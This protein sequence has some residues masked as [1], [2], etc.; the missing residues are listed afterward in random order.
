MTAFPNGEVPHSL[1][2]PSR[3]ATARNGSVLHALRIAIYMRDLAGGG[4]ER[5]AMTLAFELQSA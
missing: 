1:V 5:Q 3:P 4:V 2:V